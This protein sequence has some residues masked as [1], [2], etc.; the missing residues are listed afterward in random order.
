MADPSSLSRIIAQVAEA[1]DELDAYAPA[2]VNWY[3]RALSCVSMLVPWLVEEAEGLRTYVEDVLNS[4]ALLRLSWG[5]IREMID[6][7]GEVARIDELL[8]REAVL[9]NFVAGDTV[10][11]VVTGHLLSRFPEG[12]LA[13]NSKSDYP[14][15]FI[16]TFDYSELPARNRTSKEIG[17]AVRGKSRNPVRVPDGLEIKTSRNG[18][19]IDC[20]YPHVGLHL[21]VSFNTKGERIVVVDVLIA[22][23]RKGN[24]RIANRKTEATTVKASFGRA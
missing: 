19:N 4:P 7:P 17:A 16:R 5:K 20:H 11:V 13:G 18:A 3:D 6:S 9:L 8:E 24:Y 1:K 12:A 10:S 23:L 15:V 14:D 22:F 21:M 2:G